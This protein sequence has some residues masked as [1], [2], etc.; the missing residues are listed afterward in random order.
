MFSVFCFSGHNVQNRKYENTNK[1]PRG[2]LLSSRTLKKGGK[3]LL[4]DEEQS[5]RKQK[6]FSFNTHGASTG[7]NYPHGANNSYSALMG[8]SKQI[9][10][11]KKS[12]FNWKNIHSFIHSLVPPEAPSVLV[13]PSDQS[14]LEAPRK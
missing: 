1:F 14:L 10:I 7:T 4:N 13:C 12:A 2:A 6:W 11:E 5:Q 8:G 9:S 3:V